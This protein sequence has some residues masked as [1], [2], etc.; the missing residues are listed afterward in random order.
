MRE[1][2]S[3][4]VDTDTLK[5]INP[6]DFQLLRAA[7][8]R[9]VSVFVAVSLICGIIPGLGAFGVA[10]D[11]MVNHRSVVARHAF[12]LLLVCM[13][14]GLICAAVGVARDCVLSYIRVLQHNT[15][16]IM[17]RLDVTHKR[18]DDLWQVL[19]DLPTV[20]EDFGDEKFAEA[21]VTAIREAS[22]DPYRAAGGRPHIVRQQ[23]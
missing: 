23:N 11:E 3:T 5:A 15:E 18:V 12:S 1:T 20:I 2:L 8:P 21:R 16:Q 22:L 7:A 14:L 4:V 17:R 10:L 6:A 9:R 19:E 13:A